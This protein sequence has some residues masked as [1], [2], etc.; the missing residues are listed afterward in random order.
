[1]A[2]GTRAAAANIARRGSTRSGASAEKA[3]A[4]RRVVSRL[5]EAIRRR[6]CWRGAGV[7]VVVG[8]AGG[9]VTGGAGGG[10]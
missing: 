6:Y 7:A 8:A 1:V 5:I 3:L 4:G 10:G 2:E 9:V